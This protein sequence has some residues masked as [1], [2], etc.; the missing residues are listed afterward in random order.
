MLIEILFPIGLLVVVAKLVEGV[1]GRF[2][3][4]SIIA[5]A[6]TGAVLGPVMDEIEDELRGMGESGND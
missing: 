1:M 4:S 2:G 5:Y 3:L 6:V